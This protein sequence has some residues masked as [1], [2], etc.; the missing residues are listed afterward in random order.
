MRLE[1]KR[2][3]IHKVAPED[4]LKIIFDTLF[5]LENRIRTLEKQPH[6]S[7]NDFV[8]DAKN[9]KGGKVK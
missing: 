7:K 4:A 8:V 9:K 1:V 6:I 2:E 5:D 3:Y